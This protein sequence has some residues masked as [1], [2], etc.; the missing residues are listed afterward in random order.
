MPGAPRLH[1]TYGS[2]TLKALKIAPGIESAFNECQLLLFI[3]WHSDSPSRN[4]SYRNV[5]VVTKVMYKYIHSNIV[6]LLSSTSSVWSEPPSFLAY[7]TQVSYPASLFTLSPSRQRDRTL[8][9]V[10]LSKLFTWPI[11]G[12]SSTVT[13]HLIQNM[14][15]PSSIWNYA[16]CLCSLPVPPL[17][18]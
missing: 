4:Q 18:C 15:T 7:R 13:G 17:K 3:L 6:H 8:A 1:L 16:N 11:L 12:F 2:I 10:V 9:L 5:Q 14:S